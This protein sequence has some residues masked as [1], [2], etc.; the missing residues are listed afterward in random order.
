MGGLVAKSR[1][2]QMAK[3]AIN[4]LSGAKF[5]DV[6]FQLLEGQRLLMARLAI[7]GKFLTDF[8]MVLEVEEI[9]HRVNYFG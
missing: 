6:V 9:E 1:H 3:M 2:S 4:N 8:H 5:L 7:E